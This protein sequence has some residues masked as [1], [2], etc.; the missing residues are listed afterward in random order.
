MNIAVTHPTTF[1]RVR[2]GTERFAYELCKYLARRGHRVTMIACKPGRKEIVVDDDFETIY[3]RRLWHPSL[4]H[5]GVH[6]FQTFMIS[7]FTALLSR[8]YDVVHCCSFVDAY[9][10]AQARRVTGVPCVL[11]VNAI[12]PRVPYV[13]SI[14]LGGALYGHAVRQANEVV[15]LSRYVQQYILERFGRDGVREPVPIELDRFPLSKAREHDRPIILCAAALDDARKGGRLLM[16]AFDRLKGIRPDVR[17]H[18]SSNVAA[19]VARDLIELV[20]PRWRS[21][22]VFLGA[23]RPEDLP[24]VYGRAAVS[25]LPSLWEA[26]GM[27]IVESM[28]TGTPVVGTHDGAITELISDPGVGRT[29]ARGT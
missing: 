2:R 27:V 16:R 6:E 7:V 4:A 8:K 24:E 11:W 17:L 3:H 29:F 25:V 28:A 26:F 1:A 10:A 23:G 21:D 14:S 13:R 19:P 20:S 18:I 15:V 22:V 12:P 9:A 5:I